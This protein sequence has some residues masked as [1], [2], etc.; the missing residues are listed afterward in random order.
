MASECAALSQCYRF[1]P[2]D[3]LA[4]RSVYELKDWIH[5]LNARE[6]ARLGYREFEGTQGVG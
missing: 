5:E 4:Q 1:E 3:W 2:H 6:R